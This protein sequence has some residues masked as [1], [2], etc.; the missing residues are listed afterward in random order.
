MLMKL[1]CLVLLLG[2]VILFPCQ[3]FG[4]LE[5]ER[6][7]IG[8]A[9]YHSVS[10]NDLSVDA[11]FGEP[12]I[13]FS[14]GDLIVTVGF[15]QTE[16]SAP[17]PAPQTRAGNTNTADVEVDVAAY[18]NP[19]VERLVVDLAEH[20]NAFVELELVNL[21]GVTVR[22]LKTFEQPRVTF[23]NLTNLE[24]ATY[25]LRGINSRGKAFHLGKIVIVTH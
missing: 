25:F 17:G 4:Q 19:A 20:V 15:H 9:A 24:N 12:L 2:G 18:P 1:G 6:E 22:K 3:L 14:S 11:S 21:N 10:N 23:T 16:S 5:I 7:L 8:A 13:G